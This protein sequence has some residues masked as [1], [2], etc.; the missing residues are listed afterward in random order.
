MLRISRVVLCTAALALAQTLLTAGNDLVVDA[1]QP[2]QRPQGQNRESLTAAPN[3]RADEGKGPFKTMAIRG[4]M[5][6]D[7]TVTSRT[8]PGASSR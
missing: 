8:P 4:I 3:R 2:Q 1:Q 7:G 5:L 6:I